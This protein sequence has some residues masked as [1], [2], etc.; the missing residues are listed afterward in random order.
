MARARRLGD[1]STKARK[2]YYRASERYLK[3]ADETSGATSKRYRQL[4]RQS[5]DDAL[6]TYEPD[7]RQKFSKPIEKLASRFGVD[8][9]K[10][11]ELPKDSKA[12]EREIQRR[13][14][15][16]KQ[17]IGE[18]SKVLESSLSD[19]TVRRETEAQT[20]FRSSEIGRRIIGGYVDV[21]RD[22]ATVTDPSTGESRV[23]TSK[24]YPALFEYFGVDNLADLLEAVEGE[25][26]DKLYEM[27]DSDEIYEGV[28]L[29]IQNKVL[30]ND[31]YE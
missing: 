27:G 3:K 2:R 28:K 7:N 21:W 23:D 9:E 6:A 31:L 4:A 20:L 18:S 11:R 13:D 19:D 12:A 5:F 25:I 22:K 26:G 1:T 8:L 30:D 16:Q 29:L 24:I 15:R 17:A 10:R 14:I